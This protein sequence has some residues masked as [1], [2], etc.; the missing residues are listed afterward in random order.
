[1]AI[2]LIWAPRSEHF[3]IPLTRARRLRIVFADVAEFAQK[4]WL[5]DFD[6]R[7]LTNPKK[8]HADERLEVNGDVRMPAPPFLLL[9]NVPDQA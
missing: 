4:M 8:S 2:D 5:P 7:P 9:S 6:S 1:M 3:I